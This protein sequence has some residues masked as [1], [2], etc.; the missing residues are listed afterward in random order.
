MARWSLLLLSVVATAAA[1]DRLSTGAALPTLGGETLSGEQLQLPSA[2]TGAT[3]VLV[4]SFA[5]AASSDSKLWNERLAKD[6]GPHAPIAFRVIFLESV[7]K[8]FRSMA[9][10]G[11]RGGI[12]HE[13]W[14]RTLMVYADEDAW[15]SRLAVTSDKHS[16]VV[17]LDGYGRVRWMSTRPFN[18]AEYAE[19]RKALGR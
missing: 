18:E 11:I 17:M 19:M 12:P 9:V 16:Y 6:L 7:P 8:L 5:K 13:L 4:F 2:E 10:S 15:K 1:G 14:D 3:R